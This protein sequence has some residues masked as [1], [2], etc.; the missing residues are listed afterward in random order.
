M[1]I[2]PLSVFFSFLL[3]S[4]T[5]ILPII[6][7]FIQFHTK[8][9]PLQYPLLLHKNANSSGLNLK[10]RKVYNDEY[11]SLSKRNARTTT[12]KETNISICILFRNF[13]QQCVNIHTTHR[14]SKHGKI[15]KL[16]SILLTLSF[17]TRVRGF[18]HTETVNVCEKMLCYYCC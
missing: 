17:H 6:F 11:F 2:F 9:K 15:F 5:F 16:S 14:V 12:T 13:R 4:F 8:K 18:R 1:S 7:S 10:K 3:L